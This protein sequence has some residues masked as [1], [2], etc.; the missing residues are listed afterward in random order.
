[1]HDA[2]HRHSTI[3]TLNGSDVNHRNGL[4][5][6][7]EYIPEVRIDSEM[8]EEKHEYFSE[9]FRICRDSKPIPLK[10][11]IYIM[12]RFKHKYFNKQIYLLSFVERFETVVHDV[13]FWEV[14]ERVVVLVKVTVSSPHI[15]T[16][17]Q[18]NKGYLMSK[19]YWVNICLKID[20]YR[21]QTMR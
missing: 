4:C 7:S 18:F 5:E 20:K 12:I 11:C 13:K 9:A 6:A 15:T 10:L 3:W 2:W 14:Q 21:I 19:H 17:K 16:P 1:M 8:E